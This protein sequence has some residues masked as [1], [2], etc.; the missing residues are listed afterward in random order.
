MNIVSLLL[1]PLP[2]MRNR[3]C[4][5]DNIID[6]FT[7]VNSLFVSALCWMYFD[8]TLESLDSLTHLSAHMA[9]HL[10][11]ENRKTITKNLSG[12]KL[13]KNV[14]LQILNFVPVS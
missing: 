11:S 8:A 14:A 10:L 5:C 9:I 12:K 7:L 1:P 13:F 2:E 4:L 3:S 6:A